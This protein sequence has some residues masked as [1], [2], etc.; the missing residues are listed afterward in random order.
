MLKNYSEEA[1]ILTERLVQMTTAGDKTKL[2]FLTQSRGKISNDD[3][4][5]RG[6]YDA[7]LCHQPPRR[8]VKDDARQCPVLAHR[9]CSVYLISLNER[10]T[11]PMELRRN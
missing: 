6:K 11:L 7:S 10:C 9:G 1:A 3:L 4:F 5:L 8:A 2:T